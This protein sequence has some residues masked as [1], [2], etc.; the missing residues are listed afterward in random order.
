M[1]KTWGIVYT[2]S[3]NFNVRL[4][5]LTSIYPS[6]IP[7]RLG[8]VKLNKKKKKK[9]K[10]NITFSLK[11]NVLDYYIGCIDGAMGKFVAPITDLGLVTRSHCK[12]P[13]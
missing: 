11:N 1:V 2:V 13:Y 3:Q 6:N 9:R 10:N 5:I 8:W 7:L 4:A 12:F